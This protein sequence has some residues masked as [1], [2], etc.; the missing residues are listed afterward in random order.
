MNRP[1]IRVLIVAI[2]IA[3][4]I[5]PNAFSEIT[6]YTL[7][8][9]DGWKDIQILRNMDVVSGKRGYSDLRVAEV[10]GMPSTENGL[11]LTFDDPAATAESAYYRVGDAAA[12]LRGQP[13]YGQASGLFDYNRMLTVETLAGSVLSDAEDGNGFR[14]QFWMNSGAG[15][16]HQELLNWVAVPKDETALQGITLRME[17]ERMIWSVRNLFF[18][19]ADSGH[20]FVLT[21]GGRVT[22]RVWQQHMLT[23]EPTR[24]ALQYHI[25]GVLQ[26][27]HLA[28]DDATESRT[29]LT[30]K[31]T[32][33]E[34]TL[35]IGAHFRGALDHLVISRAT[36]AE[37]DA[38]TAA[39]GYPAPLTV[40]Y[41]T[42]DAVA[43]SATIDLANQSGKIIDIR[44][45]ADVP[46]H[47]E[48]EVR[49]KAFRSSA[50]LAQQ[51][52]AEWRTAGNGTALT[53][54][55]YAKYIRLQVIMRADR[56]NER[57][58]ILSTIT[59]RTERLTDPLPARSITAIPLTG[60]RINVRWE[61]PIDLNP[62]QYRV[63]YGTSHIGFTDSVDAGNDT[64]IVLDS[65]VDN[66]LYYIRVDSYRSEIPEFRNAKGTILSSRTN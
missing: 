38:Y 4:G 22:P 11:L 35:T 45:E 42:V 8:E 66:A 31:I 13:Y 47:G 18:D 63:W 55:V 39:H 23:Y 52:D 28:I 29:P 7:G 41:A 30:K 51:D 10:P 53:S 5:A 58:P 59:V 19:Q 61:H 36:T 33:S 16:S 14:I 15:E 57:T 56:R 62:T 64:S 26:D 32:T 9:A 54:D 48:V 65:L 12:V 46:P 1:Y 21:S 40:R 24:G 2:G 50:E 6:T 20:T 34:G 25:D 17:N 43:E 3:S 60:N 44:Y 27:A 37:A 49:Y